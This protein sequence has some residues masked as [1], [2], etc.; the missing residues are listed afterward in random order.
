MR[1]I[2]LSFLHMVKLIRQD[3]MLLAAGLAP[4]LAGTAI[5]YGVPLAEDG[6]VR[7]TGT[8]AVLV[9]YYALFDLFLASL[10]P[11][12][13]CFI[14]AMVMLEERDDHIDRHLSATALGK[15]G[16]FVSRIL[17][18]ALAAFAVTAMLLP[19]FHLSPLP[20]RAILLLSLVGT[21]QGI[22][23][24][25]LIVTIS[26][27]KLEGMAVTKLSSL[28][29]LGAVIPWFVPVPFSFAFSFLPSFWMGKAMAEGSL[30]YLLPSIAAAGC[31]IAV[32]WNRLCKACR[33]K[34]SG[35]SNHFVLIWLLMSATIILGL[36]SGIRP[37]AV[38]SG[39]ME[40]NLPTWSLCFVNTRASYDSIQTGDIV[41]FYRRS[42][43]T[44]IIHRVI[45][46]EADGMVTKGD[47]NPVSDGLSV[48]RD[49]LYGKSLFHIPYLGYV[50]KLTQNPIVKPMIILCLAALIATDIVDIC[51]SKGKKQDGF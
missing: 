1:V 27:N 38:I 47:A 45:Q 37:C 28:M 36:I 41:V 9:P 4:L 18:P 14:A 31:W 30:F 25:L 7:L 24:G 33:Q 11:A 34:K 50:S 46:I 48:G 21:M 16:Y 44:R 23:I 13:F 49:N 22:I 6:L 17:L 3:R 2:G 29:M 8:Q 35:T 39:S 10:T 19:V 51:K 5:R 15:N 32:L 43:H 40:P 42:D 20:A 26:S 12:M